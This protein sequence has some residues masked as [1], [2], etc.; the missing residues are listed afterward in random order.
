M[1]REMGEK[2]EGL[3]FTFCKAA[4]II[5]LTQ[6]YALP[7]AAGLAAVFYML[8]YASGKK[9]TRCFMVWPPL[10]AGIWATVAA[11]STYLI[12]NPL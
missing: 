7:V 1:T 11:V 2:F 10:I 3:A 5:L 6:K 4:T 8:A 12:I 9:D